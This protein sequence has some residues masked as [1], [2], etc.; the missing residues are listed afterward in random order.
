MNIVYS[1]KSNDTF[2]KVG[3]RLVMTIHKSRRQVSDDYS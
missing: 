1:Y 2:M 3:G